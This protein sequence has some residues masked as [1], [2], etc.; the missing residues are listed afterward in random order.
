M[1]F[2]DLSVPISNRAGEPHPPQIVY[3]SHEE[4]AREA[5]EALRIPL[6]AFPQGRAWAVET[7]TLSTHNGT[8]M[9]APYHYGPLSE[10]RPARTIDRIP[11]EWC[12]GD[13]VLLDFS[14]KEAGASI[15]AEEVD[16]ALQRIEYV[17]KP[18]DIVLIRTGADKKFF[19]SS[20][21]F[22]HAG[23]SAGATRYLLERGV[24]LTGIDGWGWDI[25]LNLQAESY[26]ATGNAS[27]LWEAHYL[28]QQIEYLHIEKLAN[29]DLLP[30]P[31]GFKVAAFPILVENA[32]AGWVRPVAMFP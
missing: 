16:A 18:L 20:Y 23:M 22:A 5:A 9:D 26:R 29:L 24:R 10:G 31:F 3:H 6:N 28:G 1:E 14:H 2:F 12:Y 11:L 13:G 27:V 32:S 4:G 17:L 25:P 8:H 21:F 19:D 15:A 30:R 7:V